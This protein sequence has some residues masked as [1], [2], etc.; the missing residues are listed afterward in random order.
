MLKAK[1]RKEKEITK[2]KK[3]A[4]RVKAKDKIRKVKVRQSVTLVGSQDA[5]TS[6][7]RLLEEQYLTGCK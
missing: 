3:V 6:C 1:E 4:T 7:S 5:R 2:E